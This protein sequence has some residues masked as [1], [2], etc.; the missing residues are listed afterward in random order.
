MGGTGWNNCCFGKNTRHSSIWEVSARQGGSIVLDMINV[1]F[2][3][4]N[5]VQNRICIVPIG[6]NFARLAALCKGLP[7]AAQCVCSERYLAIFS[8][9]GSSLFYGS[10][11]FLKCFLLK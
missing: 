11:V 10:M 2:D 8:S 4:L 9:D 1:L 6:R 3:S 7:R 5:N